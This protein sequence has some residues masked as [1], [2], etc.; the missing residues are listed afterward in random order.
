MGQPQV[1]DTI[2]LSDTTEVD[3]ERTTTMSL[4]T[5]IF[6]ES[7]VVLGVLGAFYTLW[8]LEDSYEKRKLMCLA[9]NR[10]LE[11]ES[12]L[13]KGKTCKHYLARL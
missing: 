10:A 4:L 1:P 11:I 5:N 9:N 7:V 3:S 12:F 13:M 2:W 6:E 8:P